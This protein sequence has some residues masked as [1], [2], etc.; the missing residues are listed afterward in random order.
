VDTG[1]GSTVGLVTG[2]LYEDGGDL[3]FDLGGLREGG[4][5]LFDGDV[6]G[7]GSA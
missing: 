6:G 7:V 5:G 3:G 4:G 1:V 2:Y